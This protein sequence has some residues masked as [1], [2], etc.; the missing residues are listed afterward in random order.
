MTSSNFFNGTIANASVPARTSPDADKM[1]RRKALCD[2][3]KKAAKLA[4][5][6]VGLSII[7]AL[8]A[9]AGAF[10]FQALEQTNEKEECIQVSSFK[11]AYRRGQRQ[12]KAA[13]RSFTLH[14]DTT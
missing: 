2:C 10:I 3:C 11:P 1:A 4:F 7:V 13:A 12:Q 5:S 6:T 9:V 14:S 8:Y